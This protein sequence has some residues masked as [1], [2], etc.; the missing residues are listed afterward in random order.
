MI[1]FGTII[2][3]ED[4]PLNLPEGMRYQAFNNS[5]QATIKLPGL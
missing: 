5:L 2:S 3:P 4:I 1:N